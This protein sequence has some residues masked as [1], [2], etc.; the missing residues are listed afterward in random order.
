VAYKFAAASRTKEMLTQSRLNG[1]H[2]ETKTAGMYA[3]HNGGCSAVYSM[4][5]VTSNFT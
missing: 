1:L 5:L 2:T 4:T 3:L